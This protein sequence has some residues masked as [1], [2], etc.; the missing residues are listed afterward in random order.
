[1]VARRHRI[2]EGDTVREA[3][4]ALERRPGVVSATPNHIARASSLVPNDPGRSGTPGGWQAVQWNFLAGAGVNAPDAWENLQRVGRPGGAGVVVAVLDTGVA[5]RD[6]GAF[7]RSPDFGS[8]RFVRGYDFVDRDAF[9]LDHNGHGTHVAGTIAQSADNGIGLTG[10]A[11]RARIMPVRVLDRFGEGDSIAIASGIRYAARRGAHVINLSFEFGAGVTADQIPDIL[12]ALRYARRRNTLV[13]G[14]SGNEAATAVAYPARSTSVFSVGAT[15]E[16]RCQAEYSNTGRGLD[17]VAPGGGEDAPVADPGCRPG[18]RSG[19]DIFQTTF[20]GRS[21][22]KFGMPAGYV[23]TSMAAPHVS[24]TA[25]LV[26][27]SGVLGRRPSPARL[28]AHLRAT[29][30]DLGPAGPDLR[31][32]SGLIDAARATTPVPPAAP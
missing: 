27:A 25:A 15:T 2:A 17:V 29:A 16:H 1:V 11:Y 7:R 20:V 18:D 8:G 32:G 9:A 30:T 14:A 21:V 13:V 22:R 10:I 3:A 4:R 24:G 12:A 31:Y 23:G 5:Y 26:V 6:R 28:E 19:R